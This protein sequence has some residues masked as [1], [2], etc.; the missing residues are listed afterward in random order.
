[1]LERCG[2]EQAQAV[3]IG[4]PA[5]KLVPRENFSTPIDFSHIPSGGSFM[6]FGPSR[7]LKHV[8]QNFLHFFKDESCGFCTPCRVGTQVLAQHFDRLCE[9]L[10]SQH[11]WELMNDTARL[12]HRTSHCGLGQTAANPFID[13]REI[14]ITAEAVA[15]KPEF[16]PLFDLAEAT[17][18]T[19]SLREESHDS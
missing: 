19:R 13:W 18:Y 12:V 14:A 17:A 2:G 10:E 7:D 11:E 3:Q 5:G 1:I 8:V 4:G 9:G 15:S 16:I 6:V